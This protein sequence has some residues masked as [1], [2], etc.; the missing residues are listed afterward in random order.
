M[1][2]GS[3]CSKAPREK[4]DAQGISQTG[5][6][7]RA[8]AG[9][10]TPTGRGK[11]ARQFGGGHTGRMFGRG[12]GWR[13]A[14]IIT[15]AEEEK[16]MV[17]IKTVRAAFRPMRTHLR[18]MGKVF[19]PQTKKA[20][21][22]YAFPARIADIH[23]SIGDWVKTGQK[24][25]TLQSEEVG[26][27]RAEFFKAS[28]DLELARRNLERERNLFERGVGARK[29]LLTAE[30]EFKVAEASLDAAEKKLHVL[31]FN[32]DQIG[33]M[34]RSHQVN[35]IISLHAPISGKIIQSNAV[36]GAM[37]DQT[38]EIL[39]IMDPTVLWVD[40]EIYERDI[41]RIKIG[42]EVRVA[43]PAYPDE[44]FN[45]KISFIS[46]VLKE[47]SR[48]VTVRTEVDNKGQKLKPGMFAD[49]TIYLDH[50]ASVLALPE[51]AILDDGEDKIIF[52]CEDG[53]FRPQVVTV[54][55]KEAG[56]CEIRSGLEA[57]EEVVTSGNY[58]LKSKMYEEILR[59][60]GVH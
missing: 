7:K 30:A 14:G 43:V 45:G 17:E 25:I 12:R 55:A 58:Q 38:T 9:V 60:A 56:F 37:V 23:I 42:Q 53:G 4:G 48:T 36:R 31:G 2:F 3:A 44:G 28:A 5:N 33:E 54:G 19:V 26:T 10:V 27:A 13:N 46:D 21:V 50:Q 16:K 1:T 20:I 18:A 57:D 8:A 51:E 40:A 32:E 59:Q 52:V 47:D 11:Q 39:T 35:P 15:L 24:L 22:S 41:A 6:E 49:M 34:G 29:N